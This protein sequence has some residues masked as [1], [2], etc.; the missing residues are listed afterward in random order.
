MNIALLVDQRARFPG[1]TWAQHGLLHGCTAAEAYQSWLEATWPYIAPRPAWHAV[2]HAMTVR[3]DRPCEIARA[4]GRTYE[5][6]CKALSKMRRQQATSAADALGG[7]GT[8]SA[9]GGPSQR[10]AGVSP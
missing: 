3:G 5:S 9:S 8:V 7:P 4:M 10:L 2:L 6:V 1:L